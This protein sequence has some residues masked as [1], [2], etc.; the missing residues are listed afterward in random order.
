M[1]NPP[2]LSP[3][4]TAQ[5][6]AEMPPSLSPDEVKVHFSDE[7]PPVLNP[8]EVER[9]LMM[10]RNL[11]GRHS[12]ELAKGFQGNSVNALQAAN[13][14]AAAQEF[15][16]HEN[17]WLE[18]AMY[19]LTVPEQ[20][21]AKQAVNILE[22]LSMM[23]TDDAREIL[24]RDQ[25]HGSDIVNFYWK[26]PN[27]FM[28]KGARFVTGLAADILIDPLSY[29][30]VG[31]LTEMGKT[32]QVAGKTLNMAKFSKT[33][34]VFY[35]GL[36]EIEKVIK[37]S[38][39]SV[40]HATMNSAEIAEHNMRALAKARD[41]D[42]L[43]PEALRLG[44]DELQ[45]S[46]IVGEK[47]K[48]LLLQKTGDAL[49]EKS[50]AKEW[51][52]GDRGLTFG[53]RIPFTDAAFEVDMPGP[54]SR[55]ANLPV[56]ALD[57]MFGLG[58]KILRSNAYGDAAYNL[59]Q[60]M[61]TKTGKVIFDLQQ[62]VRL[63]K[64]SQSEEFLGRYKVMA[65]AMLAKKQAELG[66]RFPAI[67]NA[68]TDELDN[69]IYAEDEARALAAQFGVEDEAQ[70]Q[71]L[72]TPDAQD[73]A[74]MDLLAGHP[75]AQAFIADSR[76]R[77]KELV[78]EYKARDIPFDE[79]NPFGD[80]WARRYLKRSV[81]DDYIRKMKE[82]GEAS[83]V[84]YSAL[85][86]DTTL[87]GQVDNSA[88]GR[89]YRGPLRA[90][91]KTSLEKHG[92]KLF[93][94]NPIEL[95]MQRVQEM[96]KV[97][98]DYDLA[99]AAVPYARK[100]AHPGIG[101]KEFN[102]NDYKKLTQ[103]TTDQ[104]EVSFDAFLPKFFKEQRRPTIRGQ[105]PKAGEITTDAMHTP[106]GI[107]L[108]NAVEDAQKIYLPEDI[109]SRLDYAI[110][111]WSKGGPLA[112]FLHAADFYTNVWRNNALFGASYI[113]M[114]AFSNALT[115]LTM[116]DRGG[117]MPLA[118][119]T[120]A[121]LPDTMVGRGM[122][123]LSGG[124]LSKLRE[125]MKIHVPNVAREEIAAL[126]GVSV[127]EVKELA[128][129]PQEVFHLGLED[130]VANSTMSKGV[131]FRHL[132]EHVASNRM[133]RSKL[134]QTA[135]TWADHAFLW[136]YSRGMAQF[137]DDIPKL[138]IYI[139]YLENGYSRGAA[140]EAAERLM[141]NFNNMSKGQ[142]VVAKAIPFSSFPI[143]TVDMVRD[144]LSSGHLAGL[145]IPGK[146]QAV[147]DG[148]FVPD[149]QMRD[150]FDQQLPNYTS[151]L[152]PV[153]GEVMNGM[154]ELSID[155]PWTYSTIDTIFHPEKANHPVAQLL[156]L[157]GAANV[158]A[159]EQNEEVWEENRRERE[160]LL[161]SNVDMFI[162]S[163]AREMLTLAEI[164]GSI[165]LGGFFKDRYMPTLPDAKQIERA[166]SDRARLDQ[167][168]AFHKFTNSAEFGQAFD[169]AY[170]ENWLYNM[171]FHNRMKDPDDPIA[172]QEAGT[173]G[174]WIRR[175]MRQFTLG[176]A[177]MNK[178]DSN[179]FMNTAAVKRQIQLKTASL[180]NEIIQTGAL[181]DTEKLSEKAG[182]ERLAKSYP[183]AK[184][185]LALKY[186]NEAFA[187]YYDFWLG[188]EHQHPT[189]NLLSLFG[190]DHP[191][192]NY[193][194]KPDKEVYESLY[195]RKTEKKLTTED[196]EGLV[197]EIYQ[198]K[199]L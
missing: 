29:V 133:A 156:M 195:K 190:A 67:F 39:G 192:V 36:Q 92:V 128:L 31:A 121:L 108:V 160:Q 172:M 24:S 179:F 23:T 95:V 69:G 1:E 187:E 20:M 59:L 129:T 173:R 30:G 43:N 99:A 15:Y 25:V 139:S 10:E 76:E 91:Q 169:K 176:L 166:G 40:E 51:S 17:G 85:G 122:D 114:N 65:E 50:W 8:K 90:A 112:K 155:I 88:K 82:V 196:A 191:S 181:M 143:K 141:Y 193:E 189:V 137:A 107:K 77:L 98:N 180:K 136:K 80:G 72:F 113:G 48:E 32:A 35:K 66:E 162:P 106:E 71:R 132:A 125:G 28:E 119:A 19:T 81:N 6:L 2:I 61:G 145:T 167:E 5:S 46:L 161:A 101:W 116:N 13:P 89:S 79:L 183:A 84:V 103:E 178:L 97:I 38:T 64:Q 41:V 37:S 102:I 177:S 170:S 184:E 151:V 146:V 117:V 58:K 57:N 194:G 12:D 87:M 62:N 49:T 45:K 21:M 47:E 100:G 164:N 105:F 115:W 120:L 53:A 134:G 171:V 158:P 118:K 152:H 70:I 199:G 33:E 144:T 16:S 140:A 26:D 96:E 18:N 68:I 74:R 60:E 185:I 44:L 52:E 147:L 142:T 165:D 163:Y 127:E 9:E 55:A 157:A 54:L 7:K 154:R 149:H 123:H 27:S 186:K 3:Q 175:R 135:K 4:E 83:D 126:R 174:E 63:G 22:N 182:L 159:G 150:A 94:D 198:E 168:T 131:E 148:A 34:R 110:K 14:I 153:H 78:E 130:N 109:A 197:D 188:M 111:G 75:E 11:S 73:T 138:G 104:Y 42:S 86:H 56:Q 124:A 93:V